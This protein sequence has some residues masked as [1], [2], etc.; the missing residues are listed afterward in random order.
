MASVSLS[1]SAPRLAARLR[2]PFRRRLCA[3]PRSSATRGK[4]PCVI[5]PHRPVFPG[6]PHH[7]GH[8][9]ERAGKLGLAA[10]KRRNLAEQMRLQLILRILTHEDRARDELAHVA[11]YDGRTMMRHHHCRM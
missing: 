1:S 11:A 8:G 10:R 3:F 7:I 2:T 5:K 4:E 9:I 6:A